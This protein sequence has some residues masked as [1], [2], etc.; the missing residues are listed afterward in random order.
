MGHSGL[1]DFSQAQLSLCRRSQE[2]R[3]TCS[4]SRMGLTFGLA[5]LLVTSVLQIYGGVQAEVSVTG[6]CKTL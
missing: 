3:A 5:R 4:E 6:L 1:G 2:S